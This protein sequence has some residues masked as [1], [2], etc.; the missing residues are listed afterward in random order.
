MARICFLMI[1]FYIA[2]PAEL[3]LGGEKPPTWEPTAAER[4][5]RPWLPRKS[6]EVLINKFGISMPLG[7]ILLARK[8]TEYCAIKFT[9]TWLG[10]TERDHF[11]SY[12]F[13]FQGDGSG[14]FTKSN[15][16]AGSDELYFPKIQPI[17]FDIGYQK[18]LKDTIICGGMK[19][20]WLFIA[21]L[22]FLKYELAPTPWTSIKNVN[23]QDPRV[24]W[25]KKDSD[26]KDRSVPIDQLWDH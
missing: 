2:L 9:D 15:V 13:F 26:R 7:R 21:W 3:I 12:D 25:Y 14:D 8:G 1:I 10:E 4:A 22:R 24:K 16:I 18:G 17:V 19:L 20:E 6:D 5:D 11:T 23:V